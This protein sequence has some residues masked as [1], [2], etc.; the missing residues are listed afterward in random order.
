MVAAAITRGD[1]EINNIVPGH[2]KAVIEKLIEAG[3]DITSAKNSVR[4][5]TVSYTHLRAHET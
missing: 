1:I 5:K 4:V 3:A 2:C